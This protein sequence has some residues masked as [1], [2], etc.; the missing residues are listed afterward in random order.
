[1]SSEPF[2]RAEGLGKQY[3]L[4]DSPVQRLSDLAFGS[5]RAGEHWAVRDVSLELGPGSCMGIVGRNGAGKSTLLEM[6][7]GITRPSE[8]RL[9]THGRI[10]AL[11]QLGAG[12]N[13]EFTGR[14]NVRLGA[15]LYG[16]TDAE[17]AGRMAEI[18][19]FAGIDEYFDRP[20]REYSSGM[21]AR[22]AFS[23]C[24]HVEPDILII[25]EILGIGDV[26]FQQ[27]SMRFLRRFRRHGIILFVSHSEHAVAALCDTAMWMN[28]GRVVARGDPKD[29]LYLYR[30]ELER[31]A[32]PDD[33]F[34]AGE[35]I[36]PDEGASGEVAGRPSDTAGPSEL[37]LDDPGE[38]AHDAS[39]AKVDIG[40][41][42]VPLSALEGGER[43][44]LTVSVEAGQAVAAP[45]VMFVLRNPMGQ[46]LFCG[47]SRVAAASPARLEAGQALEFSFTFDLP[48]LP[49]GSYP[50]EVFV[51]SGED[52]PVC[53]D[54]RE[55]AGILRVLSNHV[56]HGMA[57]L[58]MR[59][60]VLEVVHERV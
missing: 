25:D 38:P 52:R 29:V 49:T 42:D 47:D 43:M 4:Y 13:P 32:W 12:F 27:K 35:E 31:A 51:Y 14:E 54:H 3:A 8:G 41:G 9:E 20:V 48:Y 57:N 50:V 60:T 19:S 16:L 30:R 58:K 37:D 55:A 33:H 46:V 15:V 5:G 21:Y 23:I 26:S 45:F 6:V 24:A 1:M 28:G 2:I 11:L 39:I 56:S 44:S 17:I 10:A 36:R 53:Q 40:A 18:E 22:L 59:K 7:C 34:V